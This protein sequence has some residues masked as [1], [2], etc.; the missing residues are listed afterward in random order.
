[1]TKQQ[2]PSKRG[3]ARPNSGPKVNIEK[4]LILYAIAIRNGVGLDRA[5]RLL[6]DWDNRPE[7]LIGEKKCRKLRKYAAAKDAHEWLAGIRHIYLEHRKKWGR[8]P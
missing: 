1:M 8:K 2:L 3:G 5:R 4:N 6:A 7:Y